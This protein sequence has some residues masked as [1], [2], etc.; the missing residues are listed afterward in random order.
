MR[1]I[2]DTTIW[3]FALRRETAT[4]SA[5]E[6]ACVLELNRLAIDGDLCIGGVIR[7]E[8]LSGLRGKREFAR[9][10]NSFG[11]LAHL[12]ARRSDHDRAAEFYNR[13]LDRGIAASHFDMLICSQAVAAPARIFTTDADFV[14]YAGCL[15]IKLYEPPPQP[16]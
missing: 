6:S 7:Q 9:I 12:I 10:Q 1:V 5:K 3:S 16:A 13:C 8:L 14:H 11:K 4:L 2:A 15:P